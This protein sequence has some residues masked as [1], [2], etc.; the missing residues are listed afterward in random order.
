M[1]L[2]D[3]FRL[4]N[5]FGN[6]NQQQEILPS[7]PLFGSSDYDSWPDDKV[8]VYA[9]DYNSETPTLDKYFEMVSN[10]PE[11]TRP[12]ALRILGTGLLSALQGSTDPASEKRGFWG[13]LGNK[14]LNIDQASSVLNAPYEQKLED[15]K[16]RA[17]SIGKAANIESQLPARRALAASR[18]GNLDVARSR[19]ERLGEEGRSKAQLGMDRLELDKQKQSLNEWKARN[20]TG[21]VYAPKGGNVVVINPQTGEVIDTGISSG[22]LTEEEK[23]NLTGQ[24]RMEQIAASG[25]IRKELQNT[26]HQH[27]LAEI[28]ARGEQS[29]TTKQ[30]VPGKAPGSSG[31]SSKTLSPTQQ[32]AEIQ[33]RANQLVTE[34]PELANY[35]KIDANTK[36]VVIEEPY[37]P[38]K[39]WKWQA[40]SKPSKEEY[41]EIYEYVYGKPRATRGTSQPEPKP[42]T[43]QAAKPASTST[44]NNKREQAINI[45][46][47]NNKV[48]NEQTI[49]MV[50]ERMK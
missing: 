18:M 41:D 4:Q 48:V 22:T 35:V 42:T 16:V 6:N 33:N 26:D 38:T 46:K 31:S 5:I 39:H 19:E 21:K 32:R 8:T 12:S 25:N 50:M 7:R 43:K 30:T 37:D 29:R 13:S 20:P 9:D 36:G 40:K 24:Q 47:A 27:N 34:F 11:R 1:P 17:D 49:K 23:L 44:A 2:Q 45:L 3:Y 15:W 14:P 10:P 28:A